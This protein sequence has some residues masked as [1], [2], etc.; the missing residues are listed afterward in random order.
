MTI[1]KMTSLTMNDQRKLMMIIQALMTNSG[2]DVKSHSTA[3]QKQKKKIKTPQKTTF[4]RLS[5]AK[6]SNDR[7]SLLSPFGSKKK[8]HS[9]RTKIDFEKDESLWEENDDL[10]K[11]LSDL[12]NAHKELSAKYMTLRDKMNSNKDSLKAQLCKKYEQNE[13]DLTM[14]IEAKSTQISKMSEEIK[15]KNEEINEYKKALIS[16]E[17]ELRQKNEKLN[18]LKDELDIAQHQSSNVYILEK[19]L[20]SYQQRI[21]AQSMN[22][23]NLQKMQKKMDEKDEKIKDLEHELKIIPNLRQQIEKYKKE[24]VQLKVSSF[25]RSK[26]SHFNDEQIDTK[27]VKLEEENLCLTQRNDEIMINLKSARREIINLQSQICNESKIESRGHFMMSESTDDL[28]RELSQLKS[29][30]KRLRVSQSTQQSM[31]S[32]VDELDTKTQILKESEIKMNKMRRKLDET[33]K[34][35]ESTKKSMRNSC[36]TQQYEN[37]LNELQNAQKNVNEQRKYIDALKRDIDGMR[38]EKIMQS[39]KMKE[40]EVELNR[41]KQRYRD[42]FEYTEQQK[43]RLGEYKKAMNEMKT[44]SEKERSSLKYSEENKALKEKIGIMNQEMKCVQNACMNLMK[45]QVLMSNDLLS[46]KNKNVSGNTKKK[47]LSPL[48]VDKLSKKFNENH[49]ENER[50]VSNQRGFMN[51]QRRPQRQQQQ[52]KRPSSFAFRK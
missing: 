36:S 19:K 32:I 14:E 7:K 24:I 45:R 29:E 8:S 18:D 26:I 17:E 51:Y 6:Y 27:M 9:I 34:E 48:T 30:N 12:K 31:H 5:L 13:K 20:K 15:Y 4:R 43:H 41:T 16:N 22:E 44:V 50:N 39:G 2:F 3:D 23:S 10:S 25:G 49:K 40:Y 11:E 28:K 33:C 37:T 1:E 42:L 46:A 38:E 21:D 35:L 52:I 47:S